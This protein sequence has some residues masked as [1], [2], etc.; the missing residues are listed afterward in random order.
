VIDVEI[1][2]PAKHC[3]NEDDDYDDMPTKRG[4]GG[5]KG[6][7]KRRRK[8]THARRLYALIY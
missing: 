5:G 4:D 1:A 6:R 2:A 7:K 8:R 3:R